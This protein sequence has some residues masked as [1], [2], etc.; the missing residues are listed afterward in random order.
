MKKQSKPFLIQKE[1]ARLANQYDVRWANYLA[2]T[3]EKALELLKLEKGLK[4]LDIG[5]GTGFL[6]DKI[7]RCGKF[8]MV[9]GIDLTP[10]MLKM[11][12][13]KF[14]NGEGIYFQAAR[15]SQ[16]PFQNRIFDRIACINAFHFFEKPE[17][18]L[19]ECARVLKPNG[20]LIFIDWCRDFL[21]CKLSHVYL[22]WVVPVPR[23]YSFRQMVLWLKESGFELETALKFRAG[24]MWGM[25][26]FKA[27]KR[28]V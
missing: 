5:C 4:I 10:A 12:K 23:C 1:Y 19:R 26:A 16:L 7:R 18:A 14:P 15:A 22:K 3:H 24:W 17:E 6:E 20:Q 9:A 2:Q 25:M 27:K 11:A 13:R 21:L 28:V 8:Q